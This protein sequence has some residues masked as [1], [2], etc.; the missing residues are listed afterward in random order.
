MPKT[1]ASTSES[2]N[3]QRIASFGPPSASFYPTA[4][5][6]SSSLSSASD[7]AITSLFNP[8][9]GATAY[10]VSDSAASVVEQV[11]VSPGVIFKVFCHG[12]HGVTMLP[13]EHTQGIVGV[14]LSYDY[15]HKPVNESPSSIIFQKLA[16]YYQNHKI[17][18]NSPGRYVWS[19]ITRKPD[20]PSNSVFFVCFVW[21]RRDMCA[22]D[23]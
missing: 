6:S 18:L 16:A 7:S 8:L 4:R 5:A 1:P 15:E 12:G 19:V 14:I 11:L 21:F 23:R 22:T 9:P 3:S 20:E 10:V 2:I 17:D 13:S